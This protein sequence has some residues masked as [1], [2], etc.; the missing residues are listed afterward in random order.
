MV[1]RILIT[2]SIEETWPK[3]KTKPILFLGEWCKLYHRKSLWQDLNAKTMTYHWD[4]RK[5]LHNDYR[6]LVNLHDIFLTQLISILN[7]IHNKN[8]S[9]RYWRILIGPWLAFFVQIIFDR[10]SMLKKAIEEG[11]VNHCV[12][13]KKNSKDESTNDMSEFCTKFNDDNWNELIYGQL[14]QRCW[15]NKVSIEFIDNGIKPS[16]NLSWEKE[17]INERTVGLKN[18]IREK[19]KK[20]IPIFNSLFPKDNAYFFISSYLPWL[21]E[22]KLQIRLG[23]FP[24]FWR[25]P[26]IPNVKT[27]MNF[28]QWNLDVKNFKID[29]FEAVIAELIPQHMPKA[30]LE[31]YESLKSISE[32]TPWPTKPKIISTGTLWLSSEVFKIWIAEKTEQG[33]PLVIIQHGGHF[34]TSPFSFLEDHQIKISDKWI[35][36]GWSDNLRPKIIP[37]GNLKGFGTS[38]KYDRNGKGLLVEY[39]I[40]R[41]SYYLYAVVMGGQFLDYV[42]EQK[43]FLNSLPVAIRNKILVRVNKVDYG[44]DLGKR[45]KDFAPEAS[46]DMGHQDIRQLIKKS[47]VYISTYNAT[48]YLEAMSWNIPT[49]IFWNENHW[50]LKKDVHPYF[51][52]LKSVSIFHGSPESAANHLAEIW[53]NIDAW[54]FSES[55]QDARLIFC[56]QFAK[57]PNNALKELE[58]FFKSL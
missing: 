31:G 2:T 36:W 56:N 57:N 10:W 23:Q 26:N 17:I 53:D 5:K 14:L 6:S 33:V 15:S 3:D 20:L 22:F 32:E 54:W 38:A 42:E 49:I 52:L 51:D 34:G 27:N 4:D 18:I 46:V 29:S 12:I 16:N 50:E 30:Y 35:S 47:R 9:D 37:I 1:E 19:V 28:R 7:K 41:Y 8:Y 25:T 43:V 13:I 48:T 58:V 40:P 44:W 21:S 45:F 11:E 24:K 55:V 39:T